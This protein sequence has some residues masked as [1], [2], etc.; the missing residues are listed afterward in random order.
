MFNEAVTLDKYFFETTG[1][2]VELRSFTK[3]W[4][5]K[6]ELEIRNMSRQFP[7]R[8]RLFALMAIF[9]FVFSPLA[10]AARESTDGVRIL[11]TEFLFI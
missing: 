8:R 2:L 3:Y 5:S 7:W 10:D 9:Q 4:D 1:I 6:K 11:L